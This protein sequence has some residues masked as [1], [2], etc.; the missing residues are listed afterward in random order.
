MG[1]AHVIPELLQRVERTPDGGA[2]TVYSTRHRR[3][4]CYVSD[5]VELI[6]R[7]ALA[8]DALGGVFNVGNQGE[9]VAVGQ[10]AELIVAAVGRS[11][12]IEAGPDTP[13]S[14]ARR[15]PDMTRTGAVTGYEARVSLPEGLR[16]TY[17]WYREQVFQPAG[18]AAQ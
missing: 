14:P 1:M 9:E 16:R 13:G 15:C 11:V 5:A 12:A 7:L 6:A 3:A 17:D 2:V 8:E 4:F 18:V 10:L